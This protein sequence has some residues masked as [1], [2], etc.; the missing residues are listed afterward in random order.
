MQQSYLKIFEKQISNLRQNRYAIKLIQE[1]FIIKQYINA[2]N[3][4]I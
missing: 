1:I 3:L 2:I 4:T